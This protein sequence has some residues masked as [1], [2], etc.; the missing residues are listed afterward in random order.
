MGRCVDVCIYNY[1]DLVENFV[2]EGCE[3]KELLEKIL[4]KFGHHIG[5]KYVILCNEFYEEYNPKWE[6]MDLIKNIF[7]LKTRALWDTKKEYGISGACAYEVA[8]ELGIEYEE[9]YE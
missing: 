7:K 9:N 1:N 4:L 6:L 2:K 3:D 5:E 8:E